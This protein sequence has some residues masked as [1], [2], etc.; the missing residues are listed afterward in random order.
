MKTKQKKRRAV[1]KAK[2]HLQVLVARS[3]RPRAI[4]RAQNLF[5]HR[6]AIEKARQE[7]E[8]KKENK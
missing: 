6:V 1:S 7:R 5:T 2:H 4:K 3:A 8:V